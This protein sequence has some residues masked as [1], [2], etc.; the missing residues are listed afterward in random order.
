MGLS[1]PPDSP[2]YPAGLSRG[3]TRSHQNDRPRA[4]LMSLRNRLTPVS[5]LSISSS[6]ISKQRRLLEFEFTSTSSN[7]QYIYFGGQPIPPK[8]AC[9]GLPPD[10]EGTRLGSRRR[11]WKGSFQNLRRG[12]G[13]LTKREA[14]PLVA[15]QT[16][17]WE[18]RGAPRLRSLQLGEERRARARSERKKTEEKKKFLGA[19]GTRRSLTAMPDLS[20]AGRNVLG[21]S[22]GSRF[23]TSAWIPTF[24]LRPPAATFRLCFEGRISRAARIARPIW[25]RLMCVLKSHETRTS[26]IEHIVKSEILDPRLNSDSS[27]GEPCRWTPRDARPP[28]CA[29]AYPQ[30]QAAICHSRWC[31]RLAETGVWARTMERV[32]ESHAPRESFE[33][34]IVQI[35]PETYRSYE[36]ITKMQI[37]TV[38]GR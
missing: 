30:P 1:P 28:P 14:V 15:K 38:V 24:R 20:F 21:T 27:H 12:E 26:S 8:C 17:P 5:M 25:V 34:A 10:G 35:G 29:D 32:L 3:R 2:L 16:V 13:L 4:T 23:S 36:S 19:A 18:N 37:V 11:A 6:P 22:A 33:L 9:S 31:L 7:M